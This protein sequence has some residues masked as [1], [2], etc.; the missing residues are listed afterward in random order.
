MSEGRRVSVVVTLLSLVAML[1]MVQVQLPGWADVVASDAPE[2]TYLRTPILVVSWFQL[3]LVQLLCAASLYLLHM[4][5]AGNFF[6]RRVV[7]VTRV[8]DRLFAV[9]AVSVLCEFGAFL[10]LQVGPISI[11][12]IWL[13]LF[14]AIVAAQTHF[15]LVVALA[16]G[17]QGGPAR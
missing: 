10:A 13:L 3:I 7:L 14:S 8:V 11:P 1:L 17:S 15:R 2:F 6:G 16:R 5:W 9:L 12:I 4:F